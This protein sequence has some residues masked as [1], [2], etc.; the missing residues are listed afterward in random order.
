VAPV[1]EDTFLDTKV[2]VPLLKDS[3]EASEQME[4]ALAVVAVVVQH[5]L[6]LTQAKL[7]KAMEE[8]VFSLALLVALWPAPV[9]VAAEDTPMKLAAQA[10][11]A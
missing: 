2:L 6:Q 4:A 10:Q 8:M 7:Q 9:A 1:V 11:V 5:Q 3:L